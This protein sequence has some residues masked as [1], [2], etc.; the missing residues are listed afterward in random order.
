MRLARQL[1]AGFGLLTR[2]PVGH[3]GAD[4]A[5][6]VWS[7]PVVGAAL[8]GFGAAVY[9]VS[10][11]LGL[12]PMLSAIW[13]LVA[14][15]LATGG[16]HEDGLA[17][18]A[19]GLGGGRTRERRLAIMRDSRIGAYGACA[20]ILALAM[21]MTA[22][23]AIAT[24]WRVAAALVAAGAL[25]RAAILLALATTRPAR[26]DGLSATLAVIPGRAVLAGAGLAVMAAGLAIGPRQA[27]YLCVAAAGVALGLARLAARRIGGHT[28]DTLGAA[29]IVT[30]CVVLSLLAVP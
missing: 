21:R 17:D 7:Y 9:A 23:A 5:A 6:A 25:G 10:H 26:E 4:H 11:A 29:E 30:E 15:T 24:P 2:L 3:L 13:T 12:P 20:L 8:G 22:I 27:S 16:L 28:G 19:D 18:T 1:A 14:M